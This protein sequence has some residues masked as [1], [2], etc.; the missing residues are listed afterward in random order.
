[1]TPAALAEY[2]TLTFAFDQDMDVSVRRDGMYN[3]SYIQDQI[4]T[5]DNKQYFN[6]YTNGGSIQVY[7]DVN[8]EHMARIVYQQ[9]DGTNE[10]NN[11]VNLPAREFSVNQWIT[12]TYRGGTVESHLD[13]AIRQF[14]MT[15]EDKMNANNKL[16]E[17]DAK[18]NGTK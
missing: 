9:Y 12:K 18:Q 8:G 1:M 6:S 2:S 17:A 4:N 3:Y 15:L 11:F 5:S 7:Q 16:Y 10:A 13:D 14:E